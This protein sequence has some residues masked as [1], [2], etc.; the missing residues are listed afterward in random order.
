MTI[1]IRNLLHKNIAG[2]EPDRSHKH[3]HASDLTKELEF[4]PR[5]YRLMDVTGKGKPDRFIPTSLRVTFDYGDHL[6]WS[7]NN[8]YLRDEMYGHWQC[9]SCGRNLKKRIRLCPT[10][11]C[12]ES[13]EHK[14]RCRWEFREPKVIDPATLVQGS[15]DV[16]VKD[17]DKLRLC[18]VKTEAKDE[19]KKLLAPRQEHRHRT[20]LYLYLADADPEARKVFHTDHANILYVCKG[21]GV[22]DNTLHALLR[23]LGISDWPFTPYKEYRIKR[24]DKA[25]KQILAKGLAVKTARDEGQMLPGVC[26]TAMCKRA[27]ECPVRQQC[28]SGKYPATVK[29]TW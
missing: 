1:S 10:K 26:P 11:P 15:I 27:R 20:E 21:Y 17:G 19:F 5:E 13:E 2:L 18:E 16:I 24:N 9:L 4:C 25:L 8:K 6:Q 3:V 12:P 7:I 28:F 29:R 22:K 14:K 23:K